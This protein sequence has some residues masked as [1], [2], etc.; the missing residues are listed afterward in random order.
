[1]SRPE[2]FSW[3]G[4]LFF[5]NALGAIGAVET[6][7]ALPGHQCGRWPFRIN[8]LYV[9]NGDAVDHYEN[10]LGYSVDGALCLDPSSP[11][12]HYSNSL[13]LTAAGKVAATISDSV[14][15]TF[16]DA[17][18]PFASG[19]FLVDIYTPVVRGDFSDAYSEAFAVSGAPIED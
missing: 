8:G 17:G 2:D 18:L 19:R 12:T 14:A 13:P 1:M 5:I 4:G 16:F 3:S 6:L 10:G 11:I 9:S 7:D 15:P